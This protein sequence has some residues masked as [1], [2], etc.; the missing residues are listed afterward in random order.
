MAA[1]LQTTELQ[2]IA[3]NACTT[4]LGSA[5]K[6]DHSSV[7]GWNTEIINTILQSLI[8]RTTPSSSSGSSDTPAPQYKYIVNSTIIQHPSAPSGSGEHAGRRGMHSA[9]GA[10]WNNER[11][12]TWSFKWEGAEERGMDVVVSVTWVGV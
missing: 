11:D 6:Y 7:A 4:V 9:V 1:P 2:E 10:Y 3:Q 12:G 5:T 8:S